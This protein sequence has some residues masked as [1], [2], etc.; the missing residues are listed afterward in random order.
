MSSTSNVLAPGGDVYYSLAYPGGN[1]STKVRLYYTPA[2]RTDAVDFILNGS[3]GTITPSLKTTDN[4]CVQNVNGNVS[5][6][7]DCTND[8]NSARGNN[9]N[10]D[11]LST[12]FIQY[13]PETYSIHVYNHTAAQVTYT[14]SISGIPFPCQPATAV[15]GGTPAQ[16]SLI[17]Q[18]V[19]GQLASSS[20][21]VFS[22]YHFLYA[23]DNSPLS[24][25][26]F[27]N[28]TTLKTQSGVSFNVYSGFKYHGPVIEC[29]SG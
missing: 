25:V 9:Q 10:S 13:N 15:G 14:L 12:G 24:I 26:L 19:T 8:D 3:Q 28:P 6:N 21:G 20:Q 22:F 2:D 5:T 11:A 27:Y 29:A 7:Q 16:A 17:G 4:S 23:G 18:P 1:L